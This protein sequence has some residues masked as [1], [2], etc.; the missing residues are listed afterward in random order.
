M[1]SGSMLQQLARQAQFVFKGTV[2]RSHASTMTDL[3]PDGRTAIVRVDDIIQAPA[4]FA[5]LAG[6]DITV[7]VGGRKKFSNG[8][9]A[10]FF[11]NG[12]RIGDGV[13]VRAV[14]FL[15]AG[16]EP[17]RMKAAAALPSTSA[18]HGLTPLRAEAARRLANQELEQHVADADMVVTGRV[19]EV[20][21]AAT[22]DSEPSIRA[23]R[24][25]ANEKEAVPRPQRFSE[26]DPLW[27]E[28]V[29][30]VQAVEKGPATA[31]QVV[32]RFPS[33]TDVRWYKS[34]KFTPGQEGVFILR[35]AEQ[36]SP[37]VRSAKAFAATADQAE[38]YSVEHSTDFQPMHRAEHVRM[39]IKPAGKAASIARVISSKATLSATKT[40]KGAVRV[41]R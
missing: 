17:P 2:R 41:H 25:A 27:H 35:K 20:R 38:V 1:A 33:S 16:D 4:P 7:Q 11:A 14:E 19:T 32:V 24:V 34:P 30:D 21:S 23:R 37:T 8:T 9:S 26:H 3:T 10:I 18:P 22:P 12:W 6:Q 31:K 36:P 40:A 39:F 5:A 15:P 13:A 28:A 29:V